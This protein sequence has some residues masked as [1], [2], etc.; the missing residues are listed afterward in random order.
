MPENGDPTPSIEEQRAAID[1]DPLS[2]IEPGSVLD[3]LRSSYES[4]AGALQLDGEESLK[5]LTTP[6]HQ[7][8]DKELGRHKIAAHPKIFDDFHGTFRQALLTAPDR[9]RAA[10]Q[11]ESRLLL[12]PVYGPL[13]SE[14]WFQATMGTLVEVHTQPSP[15]KVPAA[16]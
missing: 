13:I 6:G 4:M 15:E 8:D 7:L 11:A 12:R 14:P 10:W 3:K 5:V 9:Q 16:S 2:D 1:A